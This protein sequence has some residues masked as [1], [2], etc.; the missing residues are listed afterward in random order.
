MV[1]QCFG[2]SAIGS[3]QVVSPP[4]GERCCSLPVPRAT[5]PNGE[6]LT[7]VNACHAAFDNGVIG[8]ALLD[9]YRGVVLSFATIRRSRRLRILAS[10]KQGGFRVVSA[11]WRFAAI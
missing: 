2:L 5:L 6:G 10:L 1:A 11:P 8:L 4:F 3:C 9:H 7:S